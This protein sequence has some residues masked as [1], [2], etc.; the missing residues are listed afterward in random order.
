[1]DPVLIGTLLVSMML[2]LKG[3]ADTDPAGLVAAADA[4]L[5]AAKRAGRGRSIRLRSAAD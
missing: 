5:Y 3:G 4:A 1:M 2:I